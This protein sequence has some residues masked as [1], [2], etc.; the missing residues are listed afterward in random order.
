MCPTTTALSIKM[1]KRFKENREVAKA[2]NEIGIN[3]SHLW[4]F[5]I[6]YDLPSNVSA[7]LFEKNLSSLRTVVDEVI[8]DSKK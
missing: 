3:K 1:R 6:Y 5:Y 4:F 7:K 2:L 8:K